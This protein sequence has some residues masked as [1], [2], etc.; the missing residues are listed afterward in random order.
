LHKSKNPAV[1]AL[2]AIILSDYFLS[3]NKAK[4]RSP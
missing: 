3:L 4:D 2:H 1:N